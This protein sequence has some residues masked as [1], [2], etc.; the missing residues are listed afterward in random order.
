MTAELERVAIKRL[1]DR[2]LKVAADAV[3][4]LRRRGSAASE[5]VLW[6]RLEKWH[7]KWKGRV[8][9]LTV[10]DN[11]SQTDP[12][13]LFEGSLMGALA[14]AKNWIAAPPMLKRLRKL[15]LT[16]RSQEQV[17]RL[18]D[19]WHKPITIHI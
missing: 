10:V 19:G 7:D 12:Q 3:S 16:K 14:H 17:D 6:R 8:G 9:E 4:L 18:L 13:V 2:N 15:G 11:G 1:D 5:Q